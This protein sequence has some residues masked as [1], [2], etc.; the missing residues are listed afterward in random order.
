M[1]HKYLF[2]PDREMT[3]HQ[4]ERIFFSKSDLINQVYKGHLQKCEGGVLLKS[5]GGKRQPSLKCHP[6]IGVIA[7]KMPPAGSAGT[8]TGCRVSSPHPP[9]L[10]SSLYS[11][12]ELSRDMQSLF[13]QET[14]KV[15]LLKNQTIIV[16]PFNSELPKF[17]Q[18][19][20][21]L[22]CSISQETVAQ[23][24]HQ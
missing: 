21:T 10:V 3:T 24:Q 9:I 8:S 23:K 2:A 20:S 15:D 12:G 7:G 22:K 13:T 6:T 14:G 1:L 16:S 5:R 4:R 17:K 11:L 18:P 19:P